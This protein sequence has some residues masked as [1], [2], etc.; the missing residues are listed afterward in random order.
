M[1]LALAL[2]LLVSALAFAQ[3]NGKRHPIPVPK[4]LK[5]L[6]GM[7]GAQ[8]IQ[9]MRGFDTALGVH[10]EHCHMGEEDF[11]SD[12]N[13]IKET[14]RMMIV[15]TRDINAKFPDG[16]Q[17]VSCYTCHRGAPEPTMAPPAA[18]NSAKP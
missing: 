5:V 3:E 2:A 15:M 16:K 4:N 8:V 14:G 17:H 13:P 1:R 10:C 18:A 7:N 12:A 6:T 9:V 11:A